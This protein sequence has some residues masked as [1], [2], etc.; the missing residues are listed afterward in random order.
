MWL[1]SGL[2]HLMPITPYPENNKAIAFPDLHFFFSPPDIIP[3]F[4]AG[5]EAD[6]VKL[7]SQAQLVRGMKYISSNFIYFILL[8][9]FFLQRQHLQKLSKSENSIKG[10]NLKSYPC[11]N[12]AEK[13]IYLPVEEKDLSL[14]WPNV[15]NEI[16][17]VS[18]PPSSLL[19]SLPSSLSFF[20]VSLSPT[21]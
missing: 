4:P 17:S 16:F 6:N 20:L 14:T 10:F 18:C 5:M 1:L 8:F 13:K 12:K 11:Q 3:V 2:W 19:L 21:Q 15:K 7:S 9:F